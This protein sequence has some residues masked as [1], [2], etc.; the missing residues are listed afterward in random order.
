MNNT[1]DLIV[2]LF[3]EIIRLFIIRQYAESF[4]KRRRKSIIPYIISFFVTT[5]SYFVFH[6]LFINLIVTFVGVM[7]ISLNYHA[8]IIKRVLFSVFILATSSVIDMIA[9]FLLTYNPKGN[10]YD[11]MSSFLSVGFFLISA[12]L[13]RTKNHH[14]DVSFYSGKRIILLLISTLNIITLYIISIDS[15]VT[16]KTVILLGVVLFTIDIIIISL[17]D[18]LLDKYV[19]EQENNALREQMKIYENQQRVN[20]DTEK[21]IRGIKHDMKHHC[22]EISDLAKK[23]KNQDIIN[24]IGEITDYV[25][26]ERIVQTGVDSVDGIMN[27]KIAEAIHRNIPINTHITIPDD[28]IIST[29]DMNIILGNLMD[30]AIEASERIENPSIKIDITYKMNCLFIKIVNNCCIKQ[31]AEMNSHTS[32]KDKINHGYGL[33]NVRNAVEK[34]HGNMNISYEGNTYNTEVILFLTR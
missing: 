34:Y 9:V 16:R 18:D 17:Y 24:Y 3:A 27:Y 19:M 26:D 23:G 15:I 1:L 11:I 7:I 13:I 10:N 33:V 22:I 21:R 8:D 28:L 14:K 12:L 30:N 6:N 25:I 4:L 29:F 5:V 20:I 31:K 2:T 32:K